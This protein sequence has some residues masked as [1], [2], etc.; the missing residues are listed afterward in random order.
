[1]ISE[2]APTKVVLPEPNP[3]EMT[4]FVAPG[5]SECPAD[6][7]DC[8]KRPADAEGVSK[9]PKATQSPSDQFATFIGGSGI[10]QRRVYPKIPLGNEVTDQHTRHTER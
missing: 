5:R 7:E 9:C 3:P 1:M 2:T 6:A 4:I 10:A 8:S